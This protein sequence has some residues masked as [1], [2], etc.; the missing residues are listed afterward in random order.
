MKNRIFY[1]SVSLLTLGSLFFLNSCKKEQTDNETQSVVD[2]SICESEFMRINPTVNG[3]AVNNPGVKKID[4]NS[5]TCP[6]VTISGDTTW[7]NTTNPPTMTFDYGFGCVDMDGRTRSGQM[8]A[9]F[10]KP[11]DSLGCV[12]T[13]TFNNFYSNGVKYEGT[14][15]VTRLGLASY[16]TKV[17]GGKCTGNGWVVYY[18]CDRT[19]SMTAGAN[20]PLDET[21]DVFTLT[22]TSSGTNRNGKHYTVTINSPIT[23]MATCKWLSS[24]SFS[25]TP[26]GLATRTV[27]YG[28]GSCDNKAT[29]TVNGNTFEFTMN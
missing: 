4:A 2:N 28:N 25:L 26:D 17:V 29:F 8:I 12:I 15:T 24:G 1:F 21:D 5:S 13:V 22:G 7:T 19:F 23:K 20:T 16:N 9:A 3:R 10:S 27:D 18:D 6:T 11:Y 14:V